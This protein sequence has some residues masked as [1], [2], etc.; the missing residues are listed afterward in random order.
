[1]PWCSLRGRSGARH[2][3]H[4]RAPRRSARGS[5][6]LCSSRP[7]RCAP[8]RG[9]CQVGTGKQVCQ[10][11]WKAGLATE[12]PRN[13]PGRPC[14]ASAAGV[15]SGG[16]HR[17]SRNR[18]GDRPVCRRSAASAGA[19]TRSPHLVRT[20]ARPGLSE[21]AAADR[22]KCCAIRAALNYRTY[23]EHEQD[24]TACQPWWWL[25]HKAGIERGVSV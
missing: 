4:A 12:S 24:P 20:S 21:R 9:R 15:P 17:R 18:N 7:L 13:P 11:N 22:R 25:L 10:S 6:W 16:S 19:R 23:K 8:R 3:R 2:P 1:M 14:S 5:G